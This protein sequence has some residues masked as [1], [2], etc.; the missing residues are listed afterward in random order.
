[1]LVM[2]LGDIEAARLALLG[3]RADHG[4]FLI[5]S[6]ESFEHTDGPAHRLPG[7]DEIPGRARLLPSRFSKSRLG[8]SLALRGRIDPHL[9]LA[10]V[11]IIGGLEDRRRAKLRDG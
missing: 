10:V 7:R 2:I 4:D 3:S 5:E 6:D 1:M 11:T 9:P 8:P